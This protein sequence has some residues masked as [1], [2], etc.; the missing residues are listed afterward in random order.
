MRS[1][2]NLILC[3]LLIIAWAGPLHAEPWFAVETGHK[4]AACHVNPTGG[5]KR[6]AYGNA[7]A[8][9]VLTQRSLGEQWGEFWD[10][11]I[12]KRVRVG[13]DV[14]ANLTET[15]IP[16][17]ENSFQYDFEEAVVY[18]ELRLI[19]DMLT[20]YFDERM[21][22]GGAV[23]REAYALFRHAN[24]HA[25]A[26][27][28]FLPFGWRLEDDSEFIRQA[29]GINYATPDDGIEFGY[30][31]PRGSV[32]LAI[33]N[34]TAGAGENDRG[35]QYSMRGEYI[36]NKW[37]AGASF[38][39]NDADAGDR[40]MQGVFAGLRTGRINWLAEADFISDE[41]FSDGKREQWAVFAEANVRLRRGHN[42]KVSYGW[43]DPDDN[44]DEDERERASLV[45]E[46]FP[47][48]F[49]QFSLGARLNEGI[50]QNDFQNIDEIFLQLHLFF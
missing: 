1:A 44:I 4:C 16:N 23:N 25:K 41:S 17:Q 27:R 43:F 33:S 31:A 36:R 40:Q 48:P 15:R 19:E 50:P 21:A 18:L 46:L 34:G 8:Q 7:F 24:W 12:D 13:G 39:F 47:L 2:F 35:K 26:G 37:R 42:L 10:G 38:N 29:S 9:M 28:M 11:R 20:F 5:G 22:P 14:R 45:W 6:T 3:V 49:T 30:E 32:Q